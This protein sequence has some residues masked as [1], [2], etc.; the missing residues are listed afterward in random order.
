MVSVKQK[1]LEGIIRKNISEIIQFGVKDPDVGFVTIT[2]VQVSNDHSYAKVFVTF[3][4]QNPR[5]QAGLRALNRA[6]G[7]IRSELSK[8]M[9]IRRVPELSFVIDETEMNGR[10]ID[11]IIARIHREE[12][13]E[14]EQFMKQKRN[15]LLFLLGKDSF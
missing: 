14:S 6:A 12:N 5:M 4:G 13:K 7:F 1:R 9:T 10:H 2:D 3:L 15:L 11:E 8:R